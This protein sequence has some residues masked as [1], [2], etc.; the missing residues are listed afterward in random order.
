[1]SDLGT[2]SG[3]HLK[4]ILSTLKPERTTRESDWD[5]ARQS[6]GA[7]RSPAGQDADGSLRSGDNRQL[8][9]PRH[10]KY[11]SG[12]PLP[13]HEQAKSYLNRRET[14]SAV[15]QRMTSSWPAVRPAN[16]QRLISGWPAVDQSFV[17]RTKPALRSWLQTNG[18][19]P[20]VSV[21]NPFQARH[22]REEEIWQA[23]RL[24]R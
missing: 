5:G 16:N 3:K 18:L 4:P 14:K 10:R 1:M 6:G 11:M 23:S 7:R 9:P 22:V 21:I 17:R 15:D 20:S 2:R 12:T 8:Y 13:K 24:D 19:S